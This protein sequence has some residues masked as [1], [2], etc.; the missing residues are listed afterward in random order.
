MK[1]LK[2]A[3]DGVASFAL[4]QL[5]IMACVVLAPPY[6][7]AALALWASAGIIVAERRSWRWYKEGKWFSISLALVRAIIFPLAIASENATVKV[8][9]YIA[10]GLYRT[11]A[12]SSFEWLGQL[13]TKKWSERIT[14]GRYKLWCLFWDAIGLT[15]IFAWLTI[16][17]PFKLWRFLRNLRAQLNSPRRG[18]PM[19]HETRFVL[20]ILALFIFAIALSVV[21][22]HVIAPWHMLN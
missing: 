8:Y 3:T 20:T 16:S 14:L 10:L 22:H 1:W 2:I 9:Y 12:S 4:L 13:Y 15:A 17:W 21:L 18:H 19:S 11:A 6:G 5:Y 7:W